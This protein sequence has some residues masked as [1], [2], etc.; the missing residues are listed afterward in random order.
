[1][2][3]DVSTTDGFLHLSP[4]VLVV[5]MRADCSCCYW[6][7]ESHLPSRRDPKSI[8]FRSRST[9][10]RPIELP[11]N[12]ERTTRL[13]ASHRLQRLPHPPTFQL[14]S[15]DRTVQDQRKSRLRR[16]LATS[17]SLAPSA[18]SEEHRHEFKYRLPITMPP[19]QAVQV[20]HGHRLHTVGLAREP[21]WDRLLPKLLSGLAL[22]RHLAALAGAVVERF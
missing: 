14:E 20:E 13:A 16:S 8:I 12:N 10:S 15:G 1:M 21:C 22:A 11:T 5:C 9:R 3:D 19:R 7:V 4:S 2:S 17:I 6:Q 18:N